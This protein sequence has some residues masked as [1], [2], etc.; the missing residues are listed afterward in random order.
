[1]SD[2]AAR[3][4]ARQTIIN[5]CLALAACIALV[6]TIVLIVPRDDSNRIKEV[7]YSTI[8]RTANKDTKLNIITINPPA[9]WWCNSAE[10]TLKAIDAVQ[11]FKAGFVGS[12]VKYIG[13]TQAFETN[14]T[15]LALKLNGKVLTGEY[16]SGKYTWQ[17]YKSVVQSTPAKTMDYMMVLNNQ[18]NDYVFLYGVA[19]TQEFEV[20]ANEIEDRLRGM[21][22]ID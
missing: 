8:S 9:N 12:D 6:V 14:P 20:F 17:I 21:T 19:D 2:S 3:H 15:W 18:K 5:L 4:R 1:L 16:S 13:Y 10:F 22:G 11:T 7:D